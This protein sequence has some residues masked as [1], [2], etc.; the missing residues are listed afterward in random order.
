MLS[1]FLTNNVLGKE[2][3]SLLIILF[4][5]TKDGM[6]RQELLDFMESR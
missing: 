4:R 6:D 1:S 5:A 3:I 2:I